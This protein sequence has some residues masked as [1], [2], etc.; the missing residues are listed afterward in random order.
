MDSGRKAA[1]VDYRRVHSPLGSRFVDLFDEVLRLNGRLIAASKMTTRVS[2]LRPPHWIVLSAV[3]CAGE[4]PTVPRI[5]RA[6]GQARQSVQR[7]A[8]HLVDGGYLTWIDNPDHLRAKRLFATDK[9][10]RTYD[11]GN[12]ESAIWID[13]I[14]KGL[15]AE[16]LD[17]AV[18]LLREL[19]HRVEADARR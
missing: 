15:N 13:R 12:R 3:V 5:G 7:H 1:A 16:Q 2:G 10:L 11:T 6:L 19:R 17:A 8:D 14:V 4:P 9:G 18:T